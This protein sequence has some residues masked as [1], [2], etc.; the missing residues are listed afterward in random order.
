MKILL[1]DDEALA[2]QRL[3][4]MLKQ[5][6]EAHVIGEAEDGVAALEAIETLQPDVVFLD[7]EMPGCNG[8]EVVRSLQ[9][10]ALPCIVFCTAYDRYAVEA[11]EVHAVDYLLKPVKSERL[12]EALGRA[13]AHLERPK[14][15]QNALAQAAHQIQETAAPLR[16]FLGRKG[17]KIFLIQEP[18]VLAFKAEQGITYVLAADGRYWVNATLSELE[19]QVDARIFFRT[20]RQSIVNLNQVREISPLFQGS[21]QLTLRNGA[22]LE[23]SRRQAAELFKRMGK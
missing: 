3:G 22:E 23:V 21:Y 9:V 1:A 4:Q 16:R 2:R 17:K 13:R 11:F 10:E 20:H 7:V 19:S 15:Y 5:F 6:P 14:P 8:I 18:D 12:G